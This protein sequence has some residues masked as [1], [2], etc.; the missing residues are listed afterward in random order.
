MEKPTSYPKIKLK[1]N[2]TFSNFVVGKL[3]SKASP[4]AK[5]SQDNP[6]LSALKNS[7]PPGV[8]ILKRGGSVPNLLRQKVRVLNEK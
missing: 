1:K 5:M 8:G 3:Q 7:K 4:F 6:L 2:P